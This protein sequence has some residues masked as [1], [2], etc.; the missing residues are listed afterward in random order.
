MYGRYEDVEEFE[1][2]RGGEGEGKGKNTN[3][4]GVQPS[5]LETAVKGLVQKYFNGTDGF[6]E[7]HPATDESLVAQQK[8]GLWDV[9]DGDS[10]LW[11]E[12]NWNDLGF[13]VF[14][15]SGEEAGVGLAMNIIGTAAGL[16]SLAG[17][18]GLALKLGKDKQL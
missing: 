15:D 18:W 11:T 17:A 16:A 5:E 12:P 9:S 13:A 4:V 6:V 7:Y 2:G 14:N 3:F 1:K 10:E 8:I